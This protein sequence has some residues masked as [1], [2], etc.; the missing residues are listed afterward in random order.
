MRAS[1]IRLAAESDAA[2]LRDVYAPYVEETTVTFETSVP[3]VSEMR[4]RVA[5]TIERYP[6]LVCERGGEL[7]GYAHAGPLRERGAYRWTTEGSVYVAE[8][9]QGEGVGT[10][11]YGTLL[12]LLDMQ[13]YV[14]LRAGITLPNPASV[15]LHESL[16]FERAGTREKVGYK[17]GA[18]HDVGWWRRELGERPDEPEEPLTVAKARESKEWQRAMAAGK[19]E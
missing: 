1:T 10:A 18:W 8:R 16:G 11:L 6:W 19:R 14:E 17:H 7:V 13:G 15:A 12:D 2:A 9:A 5:E 3:S 4:D